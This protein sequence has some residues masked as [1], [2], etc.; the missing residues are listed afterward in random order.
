[1]GRR[2]RPSRDLRGLKSYDYER[3]SEVV[4]RLNKPAWVKRYC[5]GDNEEAARR[6]AEKYGFSSHVGYLRF[7]CQLMTQYPQREKYEAAI[8]KLLTTAKDHWIGQLA[9]LEVQVDETLMK[10]ADRCNTHFGN[11]Y[12]HALNYACDHNE[13]GAI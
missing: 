8:R 6:L 10:G 4:K 13:D 1:M 11:C 2:A 12:K 5:G 7:L 9:D 3:V